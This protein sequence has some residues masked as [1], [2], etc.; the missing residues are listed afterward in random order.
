MH[1][2]RAIAHRRPFEPDPKCRALYRE[3]RSIVRRHRRIGLGNPVADREPEETPVSPATGKT[4]RFRG[5]SWNRQRRLWRAAFKPSGRHKVV[6]DFAIE[7]DA[8]RARDRAVIASG[9]YKS[10]VLNFPEEAANV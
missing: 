1:E 10:P 2:M 8:A 6:G 3:W 5:V 9:A 7:E 4:S